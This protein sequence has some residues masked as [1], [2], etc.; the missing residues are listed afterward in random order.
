MQHSH[1]K[2]SKI[3]QAVLVQPLSYNVRTFD[4]QF[5]VL[6]IF[7][8]H[9]SCFIKHAK[10]YDANL[11]QRRSHHRNLRCQLSSHS[12][13][14]NTHTRTH[15][16]M[17]NRNCHQR[18]LHQAASACTGHKK[19]VEFCFIVLLCVAFI[20]FNSTGCNTNVPSQCSRWIRNVCEWECV[21]VCV[22]GTGCATSYFEVYFYFPFEAFK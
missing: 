15:A 18:M 21:C 10:L 2:Y 8:R 6:F 4:L 20:I 13:Q 12:S 9:I 14:T 17:T 5:L 1:R 19:N 22:A 16:P 7:V 3:V 11:R